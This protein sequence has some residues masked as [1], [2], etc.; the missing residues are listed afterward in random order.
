MAK[1]VAYAPLR[2]R[3]V[4]QT[5]AFWGHMRARVNMKTPL[6]FDT[7][8]G[9]SGGST[10]TKAAPQPNRGGYRR[11]RE[12]AP[13]SSL[14]SADVAEMRRYFS[15]VVCLA[16][17]LSVSAAAETA[18]EGTGRFESWLR[19]VAAEYVHSLPHKDTG[20]GTQG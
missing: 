8:R 13:P 12:F 19:R 3:F 6:L 2:S 5:A 18:P 16:T 17:C 20:E 11:K 14:E 10:L 7:G 9:T 15:A 1:A 4:A